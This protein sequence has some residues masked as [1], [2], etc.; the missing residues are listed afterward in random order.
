MRSDTT[1]FIGDVDHPQQGCLVA[2]QHN[3]MGQ[4]QVMN[5]SGKN[6]Q[7][8]DL[9]T[10][11]IV[12]VNNDLQAAAWCPF[13]TK[14]SLYRIILGVSCFCPK[15]R[16]SDDG[17]V[18]Q[19]GLLNRE[20]R[21]VNY[22]FSPLLRCSLWNPHISTPT[23]GQTQEEWGRNATACAWTGETCPILAVRRCRGGSHWWRR[24]G[25]WNV[26]MLSSP[27]IQGLIGWHGHG[28]ESQV[29]WK[30]GGEMCRIGIC[31]T[32]CYVFVFRKAAR[33]NRFQAPSLDH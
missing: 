20:K 29:V 33:A 31:C 2:K 11:L 7:A 14:N 26:A 21:M 1:W 32:C 22:D 5:R 30:Y 9:G 19:N 27:A 16:D 28:Q 24:V 18:A 23:S 10:S 12:I 25:G 13:W 3:W 17:D 8:R 15:M 6:L 4:V